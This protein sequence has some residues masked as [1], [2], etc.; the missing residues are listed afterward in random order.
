MYTPLYSYL[1]AY[2][3][4]ADLVLYHL[5]INYSQMRVGNHS[6]EKK[7]LYKTKELDMEVSANRSQFPPQIVLVIVF[8]NSNSNSY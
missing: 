6:L 1:Y 7:Y 4:Y 2:E 3:H 5:V 8:H